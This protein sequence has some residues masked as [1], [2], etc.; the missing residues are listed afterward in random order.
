MGIKAILSL[1]SNIGNREEYLALALEQ[2]RKKTGKLLKASA[3]YSTQAWGFQ[4]EN[5]FLNQVAVIETNL[6]PNSLLA[7]ILEI[8]E[9][10]GR[11]RTISGTYESRKIDIDILFYDALVVKTES[12]TIPHPLLENR[13]F[14]LVPL[15]EVEPSFVHPVLGKT[16]L[17]LLEHC[18]DKLD[19]ILY[20]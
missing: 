16:C 1:G 10:L 14:V 13:N 5:D 4:T 6:D 18:N 20:R 17:Q 8:E 2:I 11:K 19:V 3:V 7:K 9:E 12:L 15:A